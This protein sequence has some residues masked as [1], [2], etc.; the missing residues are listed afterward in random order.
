MTKGTKEVTKKKLQHFLQAVKSVIE[1][2]STLSD[3]LKTVQI[4]YCLKGLIFFK[5]EDLVTSNILD[6]EVE[7][8]DSDCIF[9]Y[10]KFI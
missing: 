2:V 1:K 4:Q 7:S 10:E 3:K 5:K 9:T 8:T 6:Y